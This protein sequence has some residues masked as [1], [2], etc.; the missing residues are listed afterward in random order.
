MIMLSYVRIENTVKV[1]LSFKNMVNLYPMLFNSLNNIT[2]KSDKEN[3]N[4]LTSEQNNIMLQ[5]NINFVIN[6]INI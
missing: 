5:L 4:T 6:E 1:L 2:H 3:S